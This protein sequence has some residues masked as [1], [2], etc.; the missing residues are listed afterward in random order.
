[1]R[2]LTLEMSAFGPFASTQVTDFSALGSNP[3][4]LI[5]G[6]TGAGKTTLLDAICFALY[7]KT[8]GDEREGSQMRC[9]LA[10]DS[11]LTEV[12][13]SF[14]LGDKQYRIRRVPEQQRA[15]KS[16]DGYTVQKPEAQLYRID[17]DG[18]EHLLVASKV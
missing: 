3:L 16:G 13:F 17:S 6:P 4:F 15:K 11:L 12:T 8:T 14:A 10:A 9:D 1:M 2:P 5:N 7:G 18:S